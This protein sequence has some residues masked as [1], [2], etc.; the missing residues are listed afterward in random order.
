MWKPLGEALRALV[1]QGSRAVDRALHAIAEVAP[2]V[3]EG[4]PAGGLEDIDRLGART[5]TLTLR[6]VMAALDRGV[7]GVNGLDAH[8][9]L[10]RG[11]R[12]RLRVPRS[13][14]PFSL[15]RSRRRAL[16]K[17]ATIHGLRRGAGMTRWWPR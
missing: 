2:R 5:E 8:D 11:S 14:G 16:M 7:P 6:L 1:A 15:P 9:W 12:L 13:F 4:D 3:G 17:R 10:A